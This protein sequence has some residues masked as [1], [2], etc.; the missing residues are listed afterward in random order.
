ML[1]DHEGYKLLI[2]FLALVQLMLSLVYDVL[3]DENV[4]N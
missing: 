3:P 4:F 2:E 1:Y